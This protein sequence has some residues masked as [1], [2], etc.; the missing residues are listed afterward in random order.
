MT[1]GL[2]P[3]GRVSLHQPGGRQ[4]LMQQENSRDLDIESCDG[5]LSQVKKRSETLLTPPDSNFI[6][7][8]QMPSLK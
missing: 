4:H 5:N 6:T 8:H 7:V 3:G 2:T 1:P